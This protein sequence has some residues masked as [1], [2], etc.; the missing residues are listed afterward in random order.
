MA[1]VNHTHPLVTAA[2]QLARDYITYVTGRTKGP[3]PSE[4][5]STLRQAGDELLER[6]PLFFKRW[7]RVFNGVTEDRASALLIETIDENIQGYRDRQNRHPGYPPNIPWSTVLS[8]YTLSGLMAIYCQQHGMENVSEPLGERVGAYVEEHIC[9]V[10]RQKGGWVDFIE[11]FGKKEDIERKTLRIC[12][13]VLALCSALLLT[14]F[15][16][17]KQTSSL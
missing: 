1:A 15:L 12:C 7:P 9:P 11:L 8:I 13:A 3:P 5:A 14:Y 6:F 4:A 17:R 16:W 10:I 2:Y